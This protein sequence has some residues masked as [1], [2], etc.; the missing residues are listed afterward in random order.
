MNFAKWLESFNYPSD[1][2]L[3]P[4]NNE[5]SFEE[6][7]KE[8]EKEGGAIIGSGKYG[9]VLNHPQWPYVIKLLDN[10]D[11]YIAFARF[12]YKNPHPAFPKLF[13]PPQRIIPNFKRHKYQ[14]KMYLIR[15]ERLY[16]VPKDLFNLIET[17]YEQFLDYIHAIKLGKENEEIEVRLPRNLRTGKPVY[18]KIHQFVINEI[19]KNP[20]LLKFFEGF[21]I[22]L[23]SN[24]KGSID[25]HN[26][27]VMTRQNG[28]IV[29]VDPLWHGSNPYMD[30]LNQQ[31]LE[32]D[33]IPDE[34]SPPD[35]IGGKLPKFKKKIVYQKPKPY[36]DD[37]VPF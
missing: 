9:V 32:I 7:F 4:R 26:G 27:N 15:L 3:D 35:L 5:K 22:L 28:D 12:A 29:L 6:I 20:K 33:D 1:L 16:P 24:L 21:D 18:E 37:D 8:F 19:R 17:Y 23:K 25:L 30:Y 34:P 11:I 13:G 2:F 36:H 31:R 10:D 14:A